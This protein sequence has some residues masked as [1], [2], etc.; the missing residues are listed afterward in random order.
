VAAV[1]HLFHLSINRSLRPVRSLARDQERYV[2]QSIDRTNSSGDVQLY[3]RKE[4][5][6]KRWKRRASRNSVTVCTL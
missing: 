3:N 4:I 1:T 5:A 2:D 6:S